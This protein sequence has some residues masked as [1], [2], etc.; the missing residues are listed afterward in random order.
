MTSVATK[1]RL[2]RAGALTAL[3]LALAGGAAI[4]VPEPVAAQ[5]N[6]MEARIRSLEAQIR[7]LQR[8][9]F[10]GGDGRFFG[11]EI[12]PTGTPTPAATATGAA[13]SDLAA[14]L[15]SVEA[16][17]K[18]LTAQAEE[19]GNKLAQL[20]ARIGGGA[21]PAP[22]A[23]PAATPVA[24]ATPTPGPAPTPAPSPTPTVATPDSNLAAMTGG[25]SAPRPT[26]TPAPAASPT[27]R[28]AASPTPRP[29]TAAAPSAQRL[30]A[31]RAIAKPQTDDPGDDEYSY[32][33]RLWEAKFFP[34][35]QQQLKLM[36]DRYPRHPRISFARNL[37]GRAFL[38][39]GKPREAA[40][41]FL[42]NYQA[43][44]TGERA[45]DSLLYL[46]EAMRQLRDTNRGCIA[47]AEFASN[48]PREAAGRLK[49]QYDATRGGLRCT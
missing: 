49:A 13:T 31:V 14:R 7:A 46:A 26:P 29:T 44:K 28:P 3:A 48:Y 37:L 22:A 35:A 41:W 43:N 11:P 30:A 15:D 20:E 6:L 32:G 8:R 4:T 16:Q 23:T 42:Q 5:E 17:L 40:T 9:V 38:D 47:I 10:P 2:V 27:P 25:A 34:E 21:A 1:Q 18:R 36:I 39:D 24:A 19:N 12:V 33:F 45:A